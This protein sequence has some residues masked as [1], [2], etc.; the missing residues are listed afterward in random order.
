VIWRVPTAAVPFL[1]FFFALFI[2]L[3]F[4]SLLPFPGLD[5]PPFYLTVARNLAEDRGL[6]IDAI[7]SYLV[8]FRAVTHPSNEFWM[9]L[10]S[11]ILA[12]FFKILGPELSVAQTIGAVAGALLAPIAWK[13]AAVVQV[14]ASAH[15]NDTR[16]SGVPFVSG[17]LIA[18]NPL[19]AY[20]A[21]SS[22]SSVYFT[23]FAASALLAANALPFFA[24]FL[25]GFAYLARTEGALLAALL[26]VRDRSAKRAGAVL[27]GAG[28]VAI[29]WLTRNYSTF[30]TAIPVPVTSLML[31][32][33]YS[34]LFTYGGAP[35][36]IDWGNQVALRVQAA[37]ASLG[38]VLV[39]A[40]VFPLTPLTVAGYVAARSS[41]LVDRGIFAF[42]GVFLLSI[43]LFPV[44]VLHGTFYHSVGAFLPLLA[45][46]AVMG[47]LRLGH[48][49][50]RRLYQGGS[51]TAVILCG[52]GL[53][54][55][56]VQLGLA[57]GAAS[58]LHTRWAAQ[59]ET[60]ASWLSTRAVREAREALPQALGH[61]TG[62]VMTNE[63][64]TLHYASGV[65]TVML[66]W[67]DPPESAK[68][69]T[70]RYG[71]QHI[72]GFGRFG[73]YPDALDEHGAF[74]KLFEE[75][76]VWAY[77]IVR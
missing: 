46:L 31:L 21:V 51:F 71:V 1:L 39:Q 38:L 7:W 47:L 50:G 2:R 75:N 45:T 77:E 3:F 53:L 24:G 11:L 37:G 30:G 8:P 54:L 20:Q 40:L 59:F 28:L 10:P 62:P 74:H 52:A 27:L 41:R 49:A 44:P 13:T 4:A 34:A 63:P 64:H 56:F 72:V 57:A 32:P 66:P 60:A 69:V 25:A 14:E 18:V 65:P 58:E 61:S 6:V 29:P 70:L 42:A 48:A 23:L 26:M 12:P 55:T 9:P 67:G 16:I 68:E 43:L 17:L 33:D 22:D 73:R 15:K 76:G 35:S 5:D 19:L 36:P